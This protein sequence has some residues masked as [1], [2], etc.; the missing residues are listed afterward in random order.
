LK[1]FAKWVIIKQWLPMFSQSLNNVTQ[2]KLNYIMDQLNHRPRKNLG[3][4]EPYELLFKK[5]TLLIIAL[6]TW[7]R[8]LT[9]RL[10]DTLGHLKNENSIF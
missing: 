2:K 9:S 7:V 6:H 1:P 3:F 4:K 5:N 8:P 10:R